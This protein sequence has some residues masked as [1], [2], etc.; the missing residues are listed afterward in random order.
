MA[1]AVAMPGSC[2]SNSAL[3]LGTSICSRSGPKKK[4]RGKYTS[5][6]SSLEIHTEKEIKQERGADWKSMREGAF[7]GGDI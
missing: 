3:C 2:S 4:K 6:E 7:G 1:V 5:K